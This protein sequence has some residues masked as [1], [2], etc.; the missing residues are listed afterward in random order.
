MLVDRTPALK[1]GMRT[2]GTSMPVKAGKLERVPQGTARMLPQ[3]LP[4]GE[5][6]IH[7]LASPKPAPEAAFTLKQFW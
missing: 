1:C 2:P 6:G 5:T 3:T 7:S 4:P